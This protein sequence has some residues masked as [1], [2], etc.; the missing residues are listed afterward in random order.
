MSR[1]W[2]YTN[3]SNTSP[4]TPNPTPPAT[5]TSSTLPRFLLSVPAI[6]LYTAA[7][8]F[9]PICWMLGSLPGTLLIDTFIAGI[10]LLCALYFQ[11]KI[12]TLQRSVLIVLANPLAEAQS[13]TYVRNGRVGSRPE[14]AEVVFWYRVERYW[15]SAAVW[16]SVRGFRCAISSN[17][18]V[19]LV[20][21]VNIVSSMRSLHRPVCPLE[22]T[23]IS[24][25]SVAIKAASR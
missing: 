8:P 11:W 6:I 10:V 4:P 7:V 2:Y 5:T 18:L 20:D 24:S 9:T 13:E 12:A 17:N 25:S 21:R 1:P 14:K 16:C 15:V 22:Y 23:C 3:T 19:K